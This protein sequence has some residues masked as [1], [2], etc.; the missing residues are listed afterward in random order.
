MICE[1]E[2][3]LPHVGDKI[4]AVNGLSHSMVQ[5]RFSIEPQFHQAV[6]KGPELWIGSFSK[7]V[8]H[9]PAIRSG[10]QEQLQC[11]LGIL[12]K[13]KRPNPLSRASQSFVSNHI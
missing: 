2:Q 10:P 9:S 3:V 12:T 7:H 13:L 11:L 1:A 6:A 5:K 4:H 8:V